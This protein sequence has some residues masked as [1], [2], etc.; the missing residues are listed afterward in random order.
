MFIG[1]TMVIDGKTTLGS[2]MAF[3]SLSSYFM[4]PIG[5]LVSLQLSIQEASISLKRI[6]E[7]YEVERE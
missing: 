1:A 2:L 3:T 6:S 5:R 7:I 4:G